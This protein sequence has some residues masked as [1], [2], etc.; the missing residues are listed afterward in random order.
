MDL[1]EIELPSNRSFGFFF[2]VLFAAIGFY[3]LSEN[4]EM[5]S[6]T[7]FVMAAI[8]LIVTLLNSDMLLPLNRMRMLF[9]GLLGNIMS[10]IILGVI[11]F[12]LITPI[13]LC[14]KLLG[15]DELCIKLKEK[16]SFWRLRDINVGTFNNQF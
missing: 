4:L 13:S 10:P 5:P 6:Y 8:F 15:R 11:F 9:G 7:L 1:S 14:M 16:G 12:G 3:L 2:T